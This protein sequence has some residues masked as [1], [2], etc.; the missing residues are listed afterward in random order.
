MCQSQS[1]NLCHNT[2]WV[3]TLP[4]CIPD[5][6]TPHLGDGA[7]CHTR[8]SPGAKCTDR[9]DL[10]TVRGL[11]GLEI[12]GVCLFICSRYSHAMIR[13]LVGNLVRDVR[14]KHIFDACIKQFD[15]SIENMGVWASSKR[16][17]RRKSNWMLTKKWC[18]DNIWQHPMSFGGNFS[19]GASIPDLDDEMPS[20]I[21]L[22]C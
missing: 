9:C 5:I 3:D 21:P 16:R 2:K 11:F 1:S 10:R 19:S 20:P 22:R 4:G 12:V 13:D 18:Y 14:I 8:R 6:W 17:L 15:R 7:P